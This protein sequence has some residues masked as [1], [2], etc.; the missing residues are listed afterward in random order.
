MNQTA[1]TAHDQTQFQ[2]WTAS[3]T[4]R[5]SIDIIW[6]SLVTLTVCSWSSVCVNIPAQDDSDTKKWRRKA[7]MTVICLIGPEFLMVLALGQWHA[8][9]QSVKAFHDDGFTRWSMKHGFY[10]EMGGFIAITEDKVRFPLRGKSL[11][12]LVWKGLIS[13][14]VVNKVVL[15]DVE[16]I[17]DRNKA[18]KSF[19]VIALVQAVWFCINVLARF[20][21][22]L[23]VTT[24][25]LTVLAY[26]VPTASTYLLW[27]NKPRDV[28]TVEF[29]PVQATAD[30]LALPRGKWIKTP[31]DWLDREEWHGSVLFR[32][33]INLI[34]RINPSTYWTTPKENTVLRRRSDN[35]YLP[36]PHFWQGVL[37]EGVLTF[38]FFG[39]NFIAWNHSF[40]ADIER[41]L[42]RVASLLM[43]A[44]Y[45]LGA[46]WHTFVNARWP[47]HRERVRSMQRRAE[48]AQPCDQLHLSQT[49]CSTNEM[50]PRLP[51]RTRWKRFTTSMNSRVAKLR[52]NST[53]DDPELDVPLKMLLPGTLMAGLYCLSRLY[54]FVED[55][56]AFRR[57][58]AGTYN[59]VEWAA[60]LP[61]IG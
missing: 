40:P 43:V 25:E 28:E 55:G 36:C 42:W 3:P 37:F 23:R 12:Y 39:V 52:N 19:R 4:A 10:A 6:S 46:G 33:W 50:A 18:D 59:N 1:A 11:H 15:L 24:L 20:I 57:M 26:F 9:R 17:D 45:I 32:H 61:H 53:N 47:M 27:W 16:I 60:F 54:I 14:D 22:H 35:D 31:L 49:R 58:P 8:A 41:T 56:M 5:G 13:N 38:T 7:W 29:V 34:V 30:Q 44:T 51:A 48:L 2:G 21:Q